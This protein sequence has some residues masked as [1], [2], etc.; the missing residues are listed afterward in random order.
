MPIFAE[1]RPLY[2]IS[3]I[4]LILYLCSRGGKSSLIKL[5]LFNWVIKDKSRNRFLL[6]AADAGVLNV[7]VWGLDPTVNSAI[8]FG[9]AEKLLETSSN[10]VTITSIGKE[11]IK[12][13]I[14]NNVIEA[15]VNFLTRIG[16]KIT[17]TMVSDVSDTW[18]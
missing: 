5:Q 6:E 3:H 10:G 8:Q 11:Y 17:E 9:M 13:I 12:D 2:K 7:N 1:Y 16:K 18:G 14:E 4:L 15:D